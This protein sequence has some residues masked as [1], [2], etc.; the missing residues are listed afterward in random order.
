M[1]PSSLRNKGGQVSKLDDNLGRPPVTSQD[2]TFRKN[3]RPKCRLKYNVEIEHKITSLDAIAKLPIL[4]FP[5]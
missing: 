3:R 2:T 4:S 1:Q 5:Q